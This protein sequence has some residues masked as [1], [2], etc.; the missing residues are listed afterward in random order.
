[1][2]GNC[3]ILKVL[4]LNKKV[5]ILILQFLMIIAGRF[6]YTAKYFL[7]LDVSNKLIVKTWDKISQEYEKSLAFHVYWRKFSIR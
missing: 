7:L 4:I 2:A 3:T 1:M 6:T 5:L